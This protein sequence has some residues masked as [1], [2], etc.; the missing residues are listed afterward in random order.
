MR[1]LFTQ[2][3]NET[4]RKQTVYKRSPQVLEAI[5]VLSAAFI[6]SCQQLTSKIFSIAQKVAINIKD[7]N[8]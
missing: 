4:H 6:N 1:A 5:R 3:V 7:I 2:G 8:F